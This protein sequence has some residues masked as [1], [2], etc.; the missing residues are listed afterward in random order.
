MFPCI[1]LARPD[2]EAIKVWMKLT[3]IVINERSC[4]LAVIFFALNH[5]RELITI[6]HIIIFKCVCNY[7]F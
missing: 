1:F 6:W 5:K 7:D 3:I 4:I 2:I